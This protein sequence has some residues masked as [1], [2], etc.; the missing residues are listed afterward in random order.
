M[1]TLL[2]SPIAVAPGPTPTVAQWFDYHGVVAPDNRLGFGY[3]D[4]PFEP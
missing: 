4:V 2:Q 1:G 3:D